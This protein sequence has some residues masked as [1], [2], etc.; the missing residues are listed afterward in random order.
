M[1]ALERAKVV[2][3]AS[4]ME[5]PGVRA[6]AERAAGNP[7]VLA[8]LEGRRWEAPG[9]GSGAPAAPRSRCASSSLAIRLSTVRTLC[10]ATCSSA[11]LQC[12]RVASWQRS[13]IQPRETRGAAMSRAVHARTMSSSAIHSTRGL[14]TRVPSHPLLRAAP[15]LRTTPRSAVPRTRPVR[16]ASARRGSPP[17]VARA[18]ATVAPRRG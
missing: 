15:P 1:L 12:F 4:P 5:T 16:P 18:P 17:V 11:T 9:A 7:A 13:S 2:R 10:L 3:H 8:A 6:T 14:A